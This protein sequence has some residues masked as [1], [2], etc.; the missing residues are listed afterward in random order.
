MTSRIIDVRSAQ[1]LSADA[2]GFGP[3]ETIQWLNLL[4]SLSGEQMY[5]L[6]ERT[7]VSR[8]AVLEFV[9]RDRQFPRACL[10]CLKEAEHALLELPRSAGVLGVLEGTCGFLANAAL[11][12]LDQP[13]LHEFIDRLQLHINAVHQGVAQT[14]FPPRAEAGTQ[15]QVQFLSDE[16]QTMPLFSDSPA[17]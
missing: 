1:P 11:A 2:P 12:K 14:Y 7:R 13:G 10:F 4:K 9:L 17:P 6:S 5:R 8:S 3:F 16:R 15:R